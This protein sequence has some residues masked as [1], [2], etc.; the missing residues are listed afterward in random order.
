MRR[1]LTG[2]SD[3]ALV[4]AVANAGLEIKIEVPAESVRDVNPDRGY[5]LM[6]SWSLLELPRVAEPAAAPAEPKPAAAAPG[7]PLTPA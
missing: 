3:R 6:V 1:I 4:H 5:V 7:G 2:H